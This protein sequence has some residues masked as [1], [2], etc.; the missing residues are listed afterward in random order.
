MRVLLLG[1]N[2]MLGHA[3]K[4]VLSPA[5]DVLPIT[6]G[7]FDVSRMPSDVNYFPRFADSVG[8]VDYVINA[9]GVTIP[10]AKQDPAMTFFVNGAF[11]HLL[12]NHYGEKLIH[13]TTDCVYSGNDGGAPYTELSP[14]TPNDIY[15]FSKTLGE[16]TNCITLRTS[17][18][19]PGHTGLLH[20]FLQQKFCMGY[21]NHIWNGV[22]TKQ[23]GKICDKIMRDCPW[24]W[25]GVH[26]VF[27]N[28]VTKYDMLCAFKKRFG[29]DCEI[30]PTETPV[31][32]NRELSTIYYLNDWLEIPPFQQMIDEM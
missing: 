32:C 4:D 19:G 23:F 3:V 21:T 28:S 22:T 16:P 24:G 25:R 18:V 15:G 1:A 30:T 6:R 7:D 14:K 12:A 20:W 9:I 17:I 26:H 8:E 13:I 10:F 29:T 2:G 27:S 31:S 11:P 5:H